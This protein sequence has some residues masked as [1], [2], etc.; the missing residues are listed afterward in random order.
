MNCPELLNNLREN[1]AQKMQRHKPPI[2]HPLEISPWL[3]MSLLLVGI[4]L[5]AISVAMVA[6]RS[7]QSPQV[8]PGEA[9]DRQMALAQAQMLFRVVVLIAV[10]FLI[11]ALGCLAMSRWSR[12]FHE[13][14]SHERSAPTP[15]DDVWAMHKVSDSADSDPGE[16]S[17]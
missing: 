3:A 10:I 14:L 8:W 13:S 7:S 4:V 11:F 16:S 5:V 1:L 9:S 6:Q 12:R 17:R 15:V 2:I